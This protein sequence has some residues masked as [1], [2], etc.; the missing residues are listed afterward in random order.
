MLGNVFSPNYARAR[1][2]GKKIDPLDYSGMNVAVY[3]KR[4]NAWSLTERDRSQVHRTERSLYIGPNY[5]G[6][7][8]DSLEVVIE[9]RCAPFGQKI[10][11]KIVFTP[12]GVLRNSVILDSNARHFWRPIAPF[13]KVRVEIE[14]LGL[15]FEGSGYFDCNWGKEPLEEGFSHWSWSR[16]ALSDSQT[17]VAYDVTEASGQT[18]RYS[19]VLSSDGTTTIAAGPIFHDGPRTIWGLPRRVRADPGAELRLIRSLENG[20]FY[21]RSLFKTKVLG[22]KALVMHESVDCRRLVRPWVRFLTPFRMKNGIQKAI[23]GGGKV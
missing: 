21:A 7:R 2:T 10:R 23:A 14:S 19:R 9:E 20:P 13:G 18:R 22:Q 15:S 5:M 1:R 4:G 17:L 8:G 16:A 11:G 6:W 12:S 3:S